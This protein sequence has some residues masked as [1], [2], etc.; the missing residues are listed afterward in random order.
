[1]NGKQKVSPVPAPTPLM[2]YSSPAPLCSLGISFALVALS[3]QW[4]LSLISGAVGMS[5][6]SSF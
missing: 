6:V 1:M 4:P 5:C 2:S 3:L